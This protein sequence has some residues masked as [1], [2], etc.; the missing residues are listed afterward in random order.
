MA[1]LPRPPRPW[2]TRAPNDLARWQRDLQDYLAQAIA[3]IVEASADLTGKQDADATLTAIAALSDAAGLLEQTGSDT[4]TK[5][6]LGVAAS[7]SVPTRADADARFEAI[8]AAAAAITA[9][10]AGGDPHTQYAQGPSTSTDNAIARYDGTTGTIQDSAIT[11]DD[12]GVLS[13]HRIGAWSSNAD[14]AVNGYVTITDNS[15]N[16][17]KLATIA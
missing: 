4:F 10:V 11:I 16:T 14:A 13:G 2:D 8:G 7:T 6:A 17:R 9:H 1:T 15:G 5:R 12:N 3:A